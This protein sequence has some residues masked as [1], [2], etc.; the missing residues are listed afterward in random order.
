M[1]TS[2]TGCVGDAKPSAG[3]VSYNLIDTQSPP[4][5]VNTSRSMVRLLV[6]QVTLVKMQPSIH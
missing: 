3:S 2:I 1:F 5:F 6:T 4:Y